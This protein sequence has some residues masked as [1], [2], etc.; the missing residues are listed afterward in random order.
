MDE[1]VDLS[2]SSHRLTDVSDEVFMKASNTIT[3]SE[4]YQ[5]AEHESVDRQKARN[6]S[7]ECSFCGKVFGNTNALNK[8]LLTH[9]SD[10]PHVC[11]ICQRAFK[12]HDHLTGHMLTHQKRKLFTC[13]EPGCQRSYCDTH[14]LK[15]HC[16]S[17]HGAQPK[18]MPSES[19]S[20]HSA[21][22][23]AAQWEAK[24]VDAPS[25]QSNSDQTGYPTI[26]ISAP[27]TVIQT[28][29]QSA[30]SDYHSYVNYNNYSG[31]SNVV[32]G[33]G[34][35]QFTVES[36]SQ[37]KSLVGRDQ[38]IPRTAKSVYAMSRDEVV[39][40]QDM[41][42]SSQW[43]V[44]LEPGPSSVNASEAATAQTYGADSLS[45]SCWENALNEFPV[46]DLQ[47]LD[48][49]LS[50]QSSRETANCH[51]EERT[52]SSE[53][54]SQ[55]KQSPHTHITQGLTQVKKIKSETL[56]PWP[57]SGHEFSSAADLPPPAPQTQLSVLEEM[58]AVP[59]MADKAKKRVRKKKITT[60]DVLPLPICHEESVSRRPRSRP[61]FLISPSQVAMA[62]FSSESAPYLSLKKGGSVSVITRAEE[63]QES[64]ERSDCGDLSE[65]SFSWAHPASSRAGDHV[66][67]HS[68]E[69]PTFVQHGQ[70]VETTADEL[71]GSQWSPQYSEKKSLS[72]LI[73]PVSVPV[74]KGSTENSIH[75]SFMLATE[76]AAQSVEGVGLKKTRRLESLKTLI[77]P[78]PRQP[79]QLLEQEALASLRFR[80]TGCYLSQLRSPPY[81]AGQLMNPDLQ[82]APYTP[83]PMLSPLRPG[84]GLYFNKLPQQH[85]CPPLANSFISAMDRK[86]GICMVVDDTV[87]SIEPRINVGSRFQAEIPPL[88]NRLLMLYEEHPA[89]IV[90]LPWGDIASNTDTQDRVTEFLNMCCSSVLPGGGTNTELALHCLH[91]VQ[92]DVLAA[93]DLLLVRGDYRS[94]SHPLND[95]HY[96]GSD[97]WSAQEKRVFRKAVI[98]E[99]KDFQRIQNMLQSKTVYQC[100][101]YYYAMKKLKKFKQRTQEDKKE[102]GGLDST[103]SPTGPDD[104]QASR[105]GVQRS[106]TRQ[107]PIQQLQTAADTSMEYTCEE[108][109]RG[110]QKVRS[111]SAHMKTHR[112]QERNCSM[113]YSWPACNRD[114]AQQA[115]PGGELP[116][117]S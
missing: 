68:P 117:T 10:R 30:S 111:R 104:Q 5:Q 77:I 109:G 100:V 114:A 64:C 72:P 106:L 110:F 76:K 36:A 52:V 90:W 24:A 92:G 31:F 69:S 91:E 17:Q 49:I 86:D 101:E 35:G 28:N 42:G 82:L 65:D 79:Q 83:P 103:E 99:N 57:I 1:V 38:W 95:Y 61:G 73:I 13:V 84:S 19:T 7:Y 23:P 74:T 8:H 53:D 29:T 26:Y 56:P 89:Q 87:V 81:L 97:F 51:N 54:S 98:T 88:R 59:K 16:L 12:R 67:S 34:V 25:A 47:V 96:T 21:L 108:C 39:T 41:Q 32:R 43:P 11:S 20:T 105:R 70:T 113:A 94:S 6:S 55:A 112:H 115:I 4:R 48:S 66:D 62:S 18:P 14:S 37:E 46:T 33:L 80:A 44:S 85:P 102:E 58:H 60:D 116:G 3:K 22:H 93:L 63:G 78:T 50:L 15:R 71:S 107:R 75:Q 40:S 45:D 27:K 9:Q 2:H